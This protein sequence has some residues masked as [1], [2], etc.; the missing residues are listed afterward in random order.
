MTI[1]PTGRGRFALRVAAVGAGATAAAALAFAALATAWREPAT[2]F[3]LA[4]VA[5]ASVAAALGPFARRGGEPSRREALVAVVALWTLVPLLT[6]V[7]YRIDGGMAWIDAWFEAASGFT[8]TGATVLTDFGA[9]E[10]SL[11]LWRAASQW[12]G[13]IGIIVLFIA[14]FPYFRV[15]GRQLFAA[16]APGPETD[17]LA[18]RVHATARALL[19]VYL[20]L[21]VACGMAYLAA[22]MGPFDAVA[23]ALTT[24]ASGGFSPEARSF[25]AFGPAAQWVATVFMAFAGAN[26]AL[27]YRALLGRPGRLLRDAEFR[28]YLAVAAGVALLLAVAI[29]PAY[30][31]PDAVRHALFQAFSI[32]TTTGYASADFETWATPALAVLVTAMFVGGSAGSA[33][34]GIKVV[35]WR[36]LASHAGREIVRAVHPRAVVPVRVGRRPVSE[37]VV[38]AVTAFVTLFALLFAG[39]SI[40]LAFDGADAR[41]AVTAS[42]ATLANIGPGLGAVGPMESF[43]AFS[44]PAKGVLIF[45]MIAG[46]LEI[47]ALL[48]VLAPDGLHPPRRWRTRFEGRGRS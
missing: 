4:A 15:A 18:P 30:D 21:T 1:A 41:T 6:A 14:V 45:L 31:G 2:G 48:A 24:L 5:S 11:F 33:A 47:L 44:D 29:A 16:E 34:G 42:V 22:G 32:V 35:R 3:L 39:G 7:P 40:A 38:H 10:R 8:T 26:F 23:H 46:R 37:E 9:F 20:G 25:E 28:T 19:A 43:A 36:I 13:G 27:Q 17:A 12:V